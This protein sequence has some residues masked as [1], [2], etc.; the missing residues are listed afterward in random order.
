MIEGATDDLTRAATS[1]VLILVFAVLLAV[2]ARGWHRGADW[3]RTPTLLWNVLLLPVAWS[4][5]Q[6]DRPLV[7]LGVAALALSTAAASLAVPPRGPIDHDTTDD[8]RV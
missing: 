8:T 7:G 6:A 3:P 2:V 4:L 5:Y 1:T